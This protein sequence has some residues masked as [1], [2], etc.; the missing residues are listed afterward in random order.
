DA[1]LKDAIAVSAK[2]YQRKLLDRGLVAG[3]KEEKQIR[4]AAPKGAFLGHILYANG[5]PVAFQYGLVYNGTYFCEHTGYDPDWAQR[6]AGGV[7]F[8]ETLRDFE[9]RKADIKVMDFGQGLNLFK[10][11]TTNERHA[12]AHYYLFNRTTGGWMLFNTA[13]AMTG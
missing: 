8:M 9:K 6:Q 7:L 12:I 11:R 4:F 3:S 5:A 2:T 1:F 10:E 13:K